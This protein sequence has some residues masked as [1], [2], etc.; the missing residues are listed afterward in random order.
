MFKKDCKNNNYNNQNYIHTHS[1]AL[2]ETIVHSIYKR[3][4]AH[5]LYI[6]YTAYI[7][8]FSIC[9]ININDQAISNI[10]KQIYIIN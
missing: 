7:H 8:E 4:C 9:P 6:L 5:I 2:K 3:K 1:D 10:Y